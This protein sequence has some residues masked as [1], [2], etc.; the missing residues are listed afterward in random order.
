MY[1]NKFQRDHFFL[2]QRASD[3]DPECREAAYAAIGAVMKS[4]GEDGVRSLFT[5][6][7]QDE[8]KMSK[9]GAIRVFFRDS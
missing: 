2:L 3:S 6:V 7:G 5:E 1:L 4:T 8:I 9:V